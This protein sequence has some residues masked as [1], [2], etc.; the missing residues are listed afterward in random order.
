MTENWIQPPA[1]PEAGADK[2]IRSNRWFSHQL[3]IS[4]FDET[5]TEPEVKRQPFSLK[6]PFSS[7]E[8]LISLFAPKE[9]Q[10]TATKPKRPWRIYIPLISNDLVI[11]LFG[12]PEPSDPAVLPR[13]GRL[14]I[15]MLRPQAA[16]GVAMIV[17]GLLT[18]YNFGL[19]ASRSDISVPV[20]SAPPLPAPVVEA[21]PAQ[22][23]GLPRAAPA[24]IRIPGIGVNT[25]FV[26]LDKK[27]D[28]TIQVP[29]RFDIVGWYRRAPTPGE[30]GPAIMIGHVDN[31]RGPAVFYRLKDL[32]PGD[33]IEIDRVDGTTV[34]F[35][36]DSLQQF[37]QD[38]ANFP[39]AQV[40]GGID[41]AGLRL[42]TCSGQ[43]NRVTGSYSHNTVVFASVVQ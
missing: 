43:F 9:E 27:V 34:R 14:V 1:E 30:I 18:A 7:N 36:V 26:E 39:T 19:Q 8:L 33:V 35:K 11:T 12:E 10:G 20:A 22:A 17:A 29:E 16:L 21:Q 2:P 28:G 15:P 23:L 38:N 6:I 24:Q 40:Y 4:L 42:I 32:K 25:S 31:V 3:E 37:A 5:P 41:Y 13:R